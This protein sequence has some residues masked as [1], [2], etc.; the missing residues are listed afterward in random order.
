MAGLTAVEPEVFR[1]ALAGIAEGPTLARM[2]YS[3]LDDG[4]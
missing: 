2:R 4:G 3:R 1:P